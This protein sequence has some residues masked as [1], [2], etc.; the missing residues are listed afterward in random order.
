MKLLNVAMVA[1]LTL[2]ACTAT[3]KNQ[4]IE[5]KPAMNERT[6]E[7]TFWVLTELNGKPVAPAKEGTKPN[8]IYFSSE[9]NRVSVS[10]GCNVMGGGY[11][12]EEG[13]RIKFSQ[14]MSTMMACPDMTTE[15][16]LRRMT[17]NV[18][19]Y[20]I[21]GDN[22]SFAKARMAPAARFKAAAIPDGMKFD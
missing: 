4:G 2:G 15:E 18:D 16:D 10:G 19:N 22:L 14:M 1:V 17:E 8:Y 21:S 7:N 11:T 6:L 13:N 12:L 3:K 20:A 9:K 5:T